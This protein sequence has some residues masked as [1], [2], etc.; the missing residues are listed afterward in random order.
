MTID[1]AYLNQR[2]K[3]TESDAKASLKRAGKFGLATLV[4]GG[5][6][7]SSPVESNSTLAYLMLVPTFGTV[8]SAYGI[9][10]NLKSYFSLKKEMK[11]YQKEIN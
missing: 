3:E 11:N 10:E 4:C 8:F 7:I 2:I 5:I 9:Y 1:K 6:L